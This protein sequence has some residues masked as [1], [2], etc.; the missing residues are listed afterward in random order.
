MGNKADVLA[1]AATYINDLQRR[2]A[3]L[4]HLAS[5]AQRRTSAGCG[6]GR[7]AGGGSARGQPG[8]LES[9]QHVPDDGS[10]SQQGGVSGDG[11]HLVLSSNG[12]SSPDTQ[13]NGGSS[14]QGDRSDE[15]ASEE[16]GRGSGLSNSSGGSVRSEHGGCEVGDGGGTLHEFHGSKK[17]RHARS[18]SCDKSGTSASSRGSK[19]DRGRSRSS[20]SSS[21]SSS[22]A[23]RSEATAEHGQP[24]HPR[25]NGDEAL[26][27][28][29]HRVFFDQPVALAISSVNGLFVDCNWRFATESGF[30]R[31]ELLGGMTIFSL[32]R[33]ED[34]GAGSVAVGWR[35]GSNNEETVVTGSSIFGT[36]ASMVKEARTKG[37][38][39]CVF[40][41]VV[42]PDLPKDPTT[43]T[44]E[45]NKRHAEAQ[46]YLQ[47]STV[48]RG[49]SVAD[50]I[51]LSCA[52]L[53]YA[54]D[55]V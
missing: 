7:G 30:S 34:H 22:S 44:E 16:S 54:Q 41:A 10:R 31:E 45:A 25:A 55:P 40:P 17:F 14:E 3:E 4:A 32:I 28:D 26:V 42:A 46:R 33:C 53:P 19:R 36:V 8:N 51:F 50:I 23:G 18:T 6:G 48:H 38:T 43:T 5:L 21:A 15:N 13:S 35:M 2:N 37:T 20:S 47:I 27:I 24:I 52:L 29:Y 12:G 49:G 11:L 39:Q 1:T 9:L